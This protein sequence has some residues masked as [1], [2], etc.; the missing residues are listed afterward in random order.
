MPSLFV[1]LLVSTLICGALANGDPAPTWLAYAVAPGNGS[2]V[3][4]VNATWTVPPVAA[5]PGG[6]AVGW[7]FGIEPEPALNLL[8]PILAY[9]GGY[10]IF[11]GH[12]NWQGQKWWESSQIAVQ[13]GNTITSGLVWNNSTSTYTLYIACV[14]SG[15]SV[16]S[17]IQVPSSPIFTD[18]YFVVE[19]PGGVSSCSEMPSSNTFNFNNI[20]IKL[21]GE[22]ISPKWYARP[23]KPVCSISPTVV[24]AT[25]INFK[26]TSS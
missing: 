18:T 24:N 3:T 20:Q 7:W 16:S 21:D 22:V 4:S 9:E 10:L 26:W 15:K 5:H 8:Q 25:T 23:W 17:A 6:A 19:S 11:N 13:P 12:F 2:R 14:E 1:C